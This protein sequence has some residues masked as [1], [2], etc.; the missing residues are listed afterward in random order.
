[1]KQ[2]RRYDHRHPMV[3]DR[4][5]DPARGTWAPKDRSKQAKRGKRRR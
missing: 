5:G 1:M 3:A 4:T 2:P